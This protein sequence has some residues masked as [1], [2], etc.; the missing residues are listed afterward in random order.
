MKQVNIRICTSYQGYYS[1]IRALLLDHPVERNLSVK[2]FAAMS[3]YEDDYDG[4]YEE[5]CRQY[6]EEEIL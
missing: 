3:Y 5:Y 6:E 1:C 4:Q 2:K